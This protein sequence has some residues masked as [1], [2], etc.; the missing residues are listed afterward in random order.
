MLRLSKA[1]ISTLIGSYTGSEKSLFKLGKFK[2]IPYDTSRMKR[3]FI[4]IIAYF[5]RLSKL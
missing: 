2:I 4:T 5:K 3:V 1:Q